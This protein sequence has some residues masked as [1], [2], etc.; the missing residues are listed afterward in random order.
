MGRAFHL[1]EAL[2]GALLRARALADGGSQE[3]AATALLEAFDHVIELYATLDPA[4]RPE[5][6]AHLSRVYDGTIERIER[7]RHGRVAV[8]D[9]A[10]RILCPLR[11]A[12][13]VV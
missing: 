4:E 5:V 12:L 8:L 2:I 10:V 13:A 6:S 9:E 11:D 3:A 7:A 1:H